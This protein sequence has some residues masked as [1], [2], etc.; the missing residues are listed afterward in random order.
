MLVLSRRRGESIVIHVNG[1]I[2]AEVMVVQGSGEQLRL[3][4]T[5]AEAIGVDRAEVFERNHPNALAAH[6]KQ[7]K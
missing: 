3:G 6:Q 7:H 5:A 1:T 2:V 4:T